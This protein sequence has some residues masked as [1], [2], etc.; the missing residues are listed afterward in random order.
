MHRIES[1]SARLAVQALFQARGLS[2]AHAA[3][4][5]EVLV[6]TSL[7]GIDTHGLRLLPT[8]LREIDGGRA[9]RE[10]NF[11]VHGRF[12]AAG[13][14]DADNALGAV[15]ATAAMR[16]AIARATRCGVAAI[17][18]ANSN[19]FGAAA[20]YARMAIRHGQIGLV[21]SNSDALVVPFGGTLPLNG[22]NP[23]AMAA[24]GM[25]DDAFVLDMATS[26]TAYSRVLHA[27]ETGA[28]LDSSWV[29]GSR[30]VTASTDD[31]PPLRPLGGAKGQG[32]GTMIQILCALLADSPFDVELSN[33]YREPYDAPRQISHF[34]VAI[35]I[36]AFTDLARFKRRLSQLLDNFRS[37]PAEGERRVSVAGDLEQEVRHERLRNGIPL[38]AEEWRL[39]L[40]FVGE[41]Q[42][43][44]QELSEGER[45]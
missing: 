42:C 6:E 3:D 34:M 17:A 13:V 4:V 24:P 41:R 30:G 37:C 26:Q 31:L 29:V 8:Y 28:S 11:R 38:D 35:E 32:L 18:V 10:P 1:A 27:L 40:P 2:S 22:T 23:L 21:L 15:G 12:P 20:H 9:N 25:G 19:H 33:L 36:E 43:G 44:A 5:A 14:F 7:D 45:S 39:L 16:E